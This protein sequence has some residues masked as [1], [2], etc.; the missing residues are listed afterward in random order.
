MNGEKE[1][2]SFLQ[3]PSMKSIELLY[4]MY[5]MFPTVFLFP[6]PGLL[7]HCFTPSLALLR[8]GEATP[9]L[10]YDIKTHKQ[11]HTV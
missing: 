5:K 1:L 7:I 10:L 2:E 8:E 3:L 6:S 9:L 11:L 4:I